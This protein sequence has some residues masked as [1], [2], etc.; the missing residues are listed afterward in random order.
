[1]ITNPILV[2]SEKQSAPMTGSSSIQGFMAHYAAA[3]KAYFAKVSTPYPSQANLQLPRY[4]NMVPITE[5]LIDTSRLNLF[6]VN[7]NDESTLNNPTKQWDDVISYQLSPQKKYLFIDTSVS[8]STI[9]AGFLG[10]HAS[11]KIIKLIDL[12]SLQEITSFAGRCIMYECSPDETSLIIAR[13]QRGFGEQL[14][15]IKQKKEGSSSVVGQQRS[16]LA[17]GEILR[18]ELFDIVS[19]TVLKIFEN[20]QLL[21]YENDRELIVKYD[22]GEVKKI[23]IKRDVPLSFL[24]KFLSFFKAQS[25]IEVIEKEYIGTPAYTADYDLK[26]NTLILT[27]KN[28]K[29]EKFENVLS[30]SV[31]PKH[32]YLLINQTPES[33][34][35]TIKEIGKTVSGSKTLNSETTLLNCNNGNQIK[36]GYNIVTY[37]VSGDGKWLLFFGSPLQTNVLPDAVNKLLPFD[38]PVY[39]IIMLGSHKI[40]PIEENK[41]IRSAYFSAT[42]NLVVVNAQGM[43]E[44]KSVALFGTETALQAVQNRGIEAVR[45]GLPEAI[46]AG[47][48]M[49]SGFAEKAQTVFG[50]AQEKT[51]ELATKISEYVLPSAPSKSEDE[52]RRKRIEAERIKRQTEWKRQ[53]EEN[54]RKADK[55]REKREIKERKKEIVEGLPPELQALVPSDQDNGT[56]FEG[57]V[58]FD[59]PETDDEDEVIIHPIETDSSRENKS[60]NNS[61]E[62]SNKEIVQE[63]NGSK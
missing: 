1:M 15:F 18:Y 13:S 33:V 36:L 11:E 5:Y 62:V 19:Q 10:K 4:S 24:Q 58:F 45:A 61:K 46:K 59:V 49:A 50:E 39:Q 60:N 32:N 12:S 26:F 63:K 3:I 35:S 37:M 53:I 41:K 20:V 8:A 2:S 23:E 25:T 31:S 40:E 17:T 7:N 55:E 43:K 28:Q 44:E 29:Q 9:M 30:Y 57:D 56:E 38:L 22:N 48:E 21:T 47:K 51:K 52:E 16:A 34:L 42:D 54:Q 6:M 27:T 14:G